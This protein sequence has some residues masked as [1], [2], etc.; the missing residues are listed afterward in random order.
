MHASGLHVGTAIVERNLAASKMYTPS[1][2]LVH[3]EIG[4]W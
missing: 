3:K 2:P 1:L 4:V